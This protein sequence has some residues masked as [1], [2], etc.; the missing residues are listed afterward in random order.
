MIF[1]DLRHHAGRI[2]DANSTSPEAVSILV[3]RVDLTI[4]HKATL[5]IVSGRILGDDLACQ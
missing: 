1:G 4:N 5:A 3:V 2:T